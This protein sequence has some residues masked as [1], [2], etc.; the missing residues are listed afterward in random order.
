MLFV[1]VLPG[2]LDFLIMDG[3]T[4]VLFVVVLP[5]SFE[6]VAWLATFCWGIRD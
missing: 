2:T 3:V 1:V 5:G 6:R 4:L